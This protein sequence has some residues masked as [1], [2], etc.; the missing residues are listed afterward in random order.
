MSFDDN[1]II[2]IINESTMMIVVPTTTV[3]ITIVII[4]KSTIPLQSNNQAKVLIRIK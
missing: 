1:G 3:T 2:K 4:T